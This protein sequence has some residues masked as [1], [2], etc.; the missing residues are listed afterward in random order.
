MTQVLQQHSEAYRRGQ[1]DAITAL[2]HRITI[3]T[4]LTDENEFRRY[5]RDM[6]GII[7]MLLA[8]ERSRFPCKN[9]AT[10]KSPSARPRSTSRSPS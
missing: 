5:V 10:S 1:R 9:H 3:A 4:Q 2:T 8:D 6:P 7:V